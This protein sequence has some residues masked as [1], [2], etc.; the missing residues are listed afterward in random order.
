MIKLK[1]LFFL[2][3]TSLLFA[4]PVHAAFAAEGEEWDQAF[5]GV[6]SDYITF[7]TYMRLNVYDK[8]D[9]DKSKMKLLGYVDMIPEDKYAIEGT[10]YLE[11]EVD[12]MFMRSYLLDRIEFHWDGK[13]MTFPEGFSWEG[14]VVLNDIKG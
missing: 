13:N 4:A 14:E 7:R 12:D 2:L 3:V 10:Y 1:C 8:Y 11:Y 5:D 9:E 6:G